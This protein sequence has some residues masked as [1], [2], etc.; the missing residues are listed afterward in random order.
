MLQLLAERLQRP[1]DSV[2]LIALPLLLIP[3]SP[4]NHRLLAYTGQ[5]FDFYAYCAPLVPVFRP[6]LLETASIYT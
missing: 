3:T 1:F 4:A 2:S 5:P 6:P